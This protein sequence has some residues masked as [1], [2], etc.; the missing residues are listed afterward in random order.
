MICPIRAALAAA[1]LCV[2]A[3][4]PAGAAEPV[5]LD[6]AFRRVIETHPDLEAYR[7]TEVARRAEA[8][9]ARQ[10]A[11]LRMAVDAENLLGTGGESNFQSAELTLSL[12]SVIERGDKRDARF[13]VASER[14]QGVELLREAKRLDL[15]AEV[16]RRYLDATAATA[17]A[18]VTRDDL[19]QRE[20]L[21]A[22]A[23]ERR[24]AGI[25]Q[26]SAPLAAEAGRLR[27]AAELARNLSAATHARRRLAVLWGG[28]TT[29][30]ELAPINLGALPSLP[31]YEVLVRL[32]ADTPELQQFAHQAR[33][34]EAR[35][36]LARTARVADIDW[37]V[38]VR[39]LQVGSDWGLVG[40]VSIPF[41][42]ANRAQPGIHAAEAEISAI[43]FEREG[44]RRA[45]QAT[46]AEA[47]G[48]LDLAIGQARRIETDVLPALQR[49]AEAAERSYRAGASSHLEWTQL[50]GDMIEARRERLDA[51]L[52]AHRALIELQ[53]L[54]GQTF[55]VAAG[56]DN[57]VTP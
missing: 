6:D 18:A 24:K 17:L 37:Q 43:A 44:Q 53:R 38:G 9:L 21:V 51:A 25:E 20:Q 49:A 57:G 26:S 11:P 1:V 22:A 14:L 36:Q 3:S 4:A 45:L 52:T 27:V 7:F 31:D 54:T 23:A 12:A 55:T 15:L 50:Q 40:S 48:Q 46:L 29:D 42:S 2:C 16:A 35:L 34:R 47:W 8:D 56:S 30:F 10:A 41:G 32:L 5:S 33:L 19:A 28:T 13:A 39:R